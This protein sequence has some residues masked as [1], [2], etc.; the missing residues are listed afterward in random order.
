MP[1]RRPPLRPFLPAPPPSPLSGGSNYILAPYPPSKNDGG[2]C[3]TF[4]SLA[5]IVEA[6]TDVV[7]DYNF[8]GANHAP[9]VGPLG[10]SVQLNCYSPA[11]N[12]AA[13]Q[14][15]VMYVTETQIWGAIN[16]WTVSENELCDTTIV[17]GSVPKANILPRGYTLHMQP[18]IVQGLVTGVIFNVW[19]REE[20][21]V[22]DVPL[23]VPQSSPP[24]PI[25]AFELNIVGPGNRQG[26]WISGAGRIVYHA[27]PQVYAWGSHPKC[28]VFSGGT[29]EGSNVAYGRLSI[30]PSE[31]VTQ[32][33][34]ASA[35]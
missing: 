31:R 27:A 3:L 21:L 18:T 8:I 15:Y 5:V 30:Y 28:A 33:F 29:V 22:I 20:H 12:T 9:P 4:Q 13:W 16:N 7:V 11:N 2:N 26:A 23:D 1:D 19:D 14:Q 32:T 17:L 10:F 6:V 25:T 35:G 34:E 24:A